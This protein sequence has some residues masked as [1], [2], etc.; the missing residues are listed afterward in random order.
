MTTRRNSHNTKKKP[1]KF[2]VKVQRSLIPPDE[3][4]LVYDKSQR[5]CQILP[6]DWF[7]TLFHEGELKIFCLVSI[8]GTHLNIFRRVA[9]RGF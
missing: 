4:A 1:K 9:N 6:F 8:E 7:K 2:I 3:T 5:F